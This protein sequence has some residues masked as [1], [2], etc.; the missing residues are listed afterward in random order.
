MRLKNKDS[1]ISR[2]CGPEV[3]DSRGRLR[4]LTLFGF[5]LRSNLPSERL[6][7][8][9]AHRARV[10]RRQLFYFIPFNSLMRS[11]RYAARSNSKLSAAS[12]ISRVSS[13]ISSVP[14]SVCEKCDFCSL[15]L[16][17]LNT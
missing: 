11:R 9:T 1:H 7:L 3:Q 10:E 6:R 2:T 8:S 15:T 5:S 17:L 4:A 13:A 16:L 14:L 12:N